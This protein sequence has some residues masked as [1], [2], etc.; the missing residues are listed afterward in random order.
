MIFSVSLS[1]STPEQSEDLILLIIGAVFNLYLM[2]KIEFN[3]L[4]LVKF[5][6]KTHCSQQY[7]RIMVF[8][9]L[10]FSDEGDSF[11]T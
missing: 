7:H 3:L 10:V 11:A 5:N 2:K 8:L 6:E 1:W 4:L 9:R